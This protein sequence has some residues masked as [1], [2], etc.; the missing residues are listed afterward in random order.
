MNAF[1][2][3]PPALQ[4]DLLAFAQELVRIPSLSGQEGDLARLIEQKMLALGYD[5][6]SIDA[7]GNVLGRVGDGP[8]SILFDSHMD[9]VAVTDLEKWEL[10]PFGGAI[11][12]GRLYGRG[13]VDMKAS[14]AASVYAAA[15]AKS[16]GL[17]AGK[18]VYVSATVFEEDCDGEGLKHLF[19]ER[20]LRPDGV[21]ICEPS[22]NRIAL[23]HKG[24][25]QISIQTSGVSAHGAAPEK[26]MNA[27]YE[28]AE[29][30]QRVEQLNAA[31]QPS[32][33]L[34]PTL[35]LSRI[36]STSVSLNAVPTGCEIYL[37]RRMVPGESAADIHA[38]MDR[39]VQGKNAAWQVGTLR[40]TSWT[41][42]EITYQPFHLA[43]EI[44]LQHPLTQACIAAYRETFGNPPA[45][46]EFW[47]YSTNAVA[48]ISLGI[49][50]IGYGPGDAS[51]AHT[52]NEHCPV[53]E[54]VAACQ[55]YT[56]LIQHVFN[57]E[58]PE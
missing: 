54:I 42:L 34:R 14:I 21:V 57:T 11:V 41:G 6:V 26:G 48:P 49:P 2:I 25:A 19:N 46:Y 50:T 12:D 13:A 56:R 40:R 58:A 15:L 31:L 7:M 29:I 32:Q 45:Q 24:K 23:G 18:T 8:Q 17:A 20:Q 53:D 38:E 43:W 52:V 51:L 55:F 36:A 47:S 4:S 33:G 35:V 1:D 22:S 3:L 27:V 30:I 37:D 44:D 39:L 5:E 16:L 9:T 28:M 10:P